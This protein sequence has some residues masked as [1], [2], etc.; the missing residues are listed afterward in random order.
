[1]QRLLHSILAKNMQGTE[2][3]YSVPCA[4]FNKPV[5]MKPLPNIWEEPEIVHQ[6]RNVRIVSVFAV[7]LSIDIKNMCPVFKIARRIVFA[8]I[9]DGSFHAVKRLFRAGNRPAL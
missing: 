1:M 4:L 7:I 8:G 6:P 2:K 5:Q 3:M 9:A